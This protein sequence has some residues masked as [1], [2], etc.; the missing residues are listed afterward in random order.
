MCTVLNKIVTNLLANRLSKIL[1]T[2]ISD[3]QSG[4]VSGRI[5]SDNILLAQELIGKLDYKARRGNV[6]LKLG[7]MK[8]YDWLH[9]DFLYLVMDK[10]GFNGHWIDIIRRCISNYWFSLLINGQFVSYFKSKKGLRQGDSIL[11]LLFIL[12]AKYLSQG[13]N[14]LFAKYKSLNY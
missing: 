1:P 11:P 4:F 10:F 2:I 6:V 12:V 13:L 14:H 8:V 7:M 5:I 9:W 3:N